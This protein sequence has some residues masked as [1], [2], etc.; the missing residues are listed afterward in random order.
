M[1]TGDRF[2]ETLDSMPGEYEPISWGVFPLMGNDALYVRWNGGG[3]IG[4]PLAR[5]FEK[6]LADLNAGVISERAANEVYGIVCKA[7]TVD[8]EATKSKRAA[9]QQSRLAGQATQ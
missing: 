5:P 4:D 6:V 2:V 1:Q 8:K 7:G 3:G 9:M